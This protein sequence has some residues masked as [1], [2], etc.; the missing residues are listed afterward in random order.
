MQMFSAQRED[1]SVISSETERLPGMHE[2]NETHFVKFLPQRPLTS[3]ASFIRNNPL[4]PL[5]TS[6][7]SILYIYSPNTEK[8]LSTVCLCC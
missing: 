6:V 3:K 8:P 2:E 5:L 4:I 1:Y 7:F